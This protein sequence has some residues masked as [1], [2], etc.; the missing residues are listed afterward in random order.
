VVIS[1]GEVWW[2]D[3]PAPAGSGPGFR[4]PVVVV[5][6]D[7][8][9]RSRIATVVCV[10]LTSNLKW[11]A[12]PGNVPLSAALTGLPKDSVANVSQIVSVDK[13]LLGERVGKLPRAK[14]ELLLSGIE[15]VLG[16]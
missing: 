1:Q 6:G 2:A 15:L 10:P 13:E 16:R 9:N 11:G 7:V 14:L 4:R 8:I 12:A 3:L 5:Q